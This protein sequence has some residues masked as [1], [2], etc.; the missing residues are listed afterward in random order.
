MEKYREAIALFDVLLEKQPEDATSWMLQ[1]NAYVGLDEPLAAA[2]NLEAVRAIGKAQPSSLV[3]LGDI[4]M[5][6]GMPEFARSAY[7][8][9]IESDQGAT[10]FETA[11]RAA[12][13]LVRARA[14]GE[15]AAVLASIEKRYPEL[16]E[17]DELQV[18]TLRAKVARAQGENAEAAALLESIVQRDGTRGEALLELAAYYRSQGNQE[19]AILLLERAARLEGYEYRALLDHAQFM[20]A[21]QRYDE[22]T[23]LLRRALEIRREPRVE[24]FLARVEQAVR[25]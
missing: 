4:Y 20:V 13:L 23:E 11:T 15:A 9:V 12:D 3:L 19:K 6:E 22:A 18:L 24:R 14:F 25:R 5:N 7:I 17:K 8:D 21:E 16:P 1:A 10:R 2:V